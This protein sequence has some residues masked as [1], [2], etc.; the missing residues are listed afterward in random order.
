VWAAIAF[1]AVLIFGFAQP[2]WFYL[3]RGL[4]PLAST[5]SVMMIPVL[6]VVSG[7]VALGETLHWQDYTA[8]LL[9]L[10]AIGSVLLPKRAA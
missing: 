10:A 9:L 7:A 5:L 4:P 6:G 3:A 1:N 8:M 2:A